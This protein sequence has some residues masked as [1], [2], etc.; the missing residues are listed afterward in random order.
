MNKKENAG[1]QNTHLSIRESLLTLLSQKELQQ[2]TVTEICRLSGINRSTFYAHY[3]D[4]YEVM[5]A[6]QQE[7]YDEIVRDFGELYTPES[8]PLSYNYLLALAAHMK[9]HR[10]FYLAYLSGQ[11]PSAFDRNRS[12]LLNEIATPIYEQLHVPES[13]RRYY[14]NFFWWGVLAVLQQ[15]LREGCRESPKEITNVLSSCFPDY[16]RNI[17]F[18]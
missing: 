5:D 3:Q 16:S 7:L 18:A 12:I 10:T 11:Y 6:V 17:F 15:W 4:I 1:Y 9:K 2:I 13:S 14:F 8:G